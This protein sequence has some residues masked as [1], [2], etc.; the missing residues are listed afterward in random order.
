MC[1]CLLWMLFW[2]RLIFRSSN[3]PWEWPSSIGTSN[4]PKSLDRRV[5]WPVN[6]GN[7]ESCFCHVAPSTVPKCSE[8]QSSHDVMTMK[9]LHTRT[10]EVRHLLQ[11]STEVR[12]QVVQFVLH[13]GQMRSNRVVPWKQDLSKETARSHDRLTW[14]HL[15]SGELHAAFTFMFLVWLSSSTGCRYGAMATPLRLTDRKW[16][17]MFSRS[18]SKTPVQSSSH[19]GQIHAHTHTDKHHRT[20]HTCVRVCVYMCGCYLQTHSSPSRTCLSSH[21]SHVWPLT[22]GLQSHCP[23][24]PSHSGCSEPHPLHLHCEQVPPGNEGLP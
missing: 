7:I 8:N 14:I 12:G 11:Q 1:C 24:S 23:L 13:S 20:G 2:S 15:V 5:T 17:C 16:L 9:C 3:E 22:P 21:W 10:Q 4:F 19:T 6:T 18:S